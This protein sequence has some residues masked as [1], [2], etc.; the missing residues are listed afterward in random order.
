[1]ALYEAEAPYFVRPFFVKSAVYVFLI[2]IP[3]I[4]FLFL[5]PTLSCTPHAVHMG[6]FFLAEKVA[7]HFSLQLSPLVGLL[8]KPSVAEIK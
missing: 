5:Q 3:G 1:M 2:C 8:V 7:R 4:D 6:I